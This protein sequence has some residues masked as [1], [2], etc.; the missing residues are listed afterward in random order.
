MNMSEAPNDQ[1][2]SDS[3]GG[4]RIGVPRSP[5]R[6]TPSTIAY[7]MFWLALA[8]VVAIIHRL[9]RQAWTSTAGMS[10]LTADC[11]IADRL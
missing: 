9:V 11:D 4:D 5:A 7:S 1:Q 6:E 10:A 2:A 3:A 8:C